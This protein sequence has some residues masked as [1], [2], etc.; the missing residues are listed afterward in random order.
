MVS[1]IV[2]SKDGVIHKVIVQYR[3]H[4]RKCRSIQNKISTWS[5]VNSSN[6]WIKFNGRIG[7]SGIN[8]QQVILANEHLKIF[9]LGV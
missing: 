2:P 1:G 9:V 3:N 6:W 4:Q 8:S 5:G 7:K